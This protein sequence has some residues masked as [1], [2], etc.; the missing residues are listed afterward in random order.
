MI[1]NFREIGGLPV[2]GNRVVK[3]GIFYRSAMLD[4]ATDEEL[5][6]LKKLGIKLA[7]DFRDEKE[8]RGEAPYEKIGAEHRN[9]PA[10]Y[11]NDK[12]FKLEK[13]GS[14]AMLFNKITW[15]DVAPTYEHLPIGNQA[16]RAL[17]KSVVEGEVPMM[18]HC[19][20][21]KDRAG[22]G[23]SLIL[24]LLGASYETVIEEYM[25]STSVQPFIE[26]VIGERIPKIFHPYAFRHFHPFFT[27]YKELLDTSLNKIISTYGDYGTYFE[28]EFGITAEVRKELIERYTE[29]A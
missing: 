16:Y 24:L 11:K 25:R 22:I 4:R 3:K 23:I 26:S 9:I 6:E 10:T 14:F 18:L 28:K 29:E 1:A 15:R 8:C 21:G 2:D 27:V 13:G 12:L 20:A 17:M 5:N 19:T 7:Y